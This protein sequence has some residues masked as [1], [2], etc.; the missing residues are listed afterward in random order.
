MKRLFSILVLMALCGTA[1]AQ[2]KYHD[3]AIFNA[4]NG[5]VKYIEYDDG[6]ICFA[7]DG[8]LVKEESSYLELFSKYEIKRNA[9]GY[10]VSVTTDY[11]KTEFVYDE[12]HRISKRTITGSTKMIISYD[13]SAHP[14]VKISLLEQKAGQ[15]QKTEET[16]D[17][18]YFDFRGNW[19][20]KGKQGTREKVQEVDQYYVGTIGD[21]HYE[22]FV[23]NSYKYVGRESEDRRIAY[24]HNHKFNRTNSA[25]EIDL[26]YAVKNPFF[27]GVS[28]KIKDVEQYIKKNKVVHSV[29]KGYVGRR[30]IT[31]AESDKCFYGYPIANMK[32]DYFK[33]HSYPLGYSFT[34]KIADPHEQQDFLNFLAEQAIK[35]NLV[36]SIGSSSMTIEKNG[37]RVIIRTTTQDA[38]GIE[39]VK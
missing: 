34:I 35:Q 39:I 33:G 10:P 9:E 37:T 16:Y 38:G 20:Q 4:P 29:E 19:V 5:N 36:K 7:E 25:N 13:Y 15:P 2:Q 27:F 1:S 30:Y 14:S 18:N 32:Y 8:R 17:M 12:K 22:H 6:R 11:D 28:D 24:W 21:G 23:T 31:I 26:F 3:A